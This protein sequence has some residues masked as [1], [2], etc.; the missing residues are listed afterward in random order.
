MI[1][2]LDWINEGSG[3]INESIEAQYVNISI[4]IYQFPLIGSTCIELPDELKNT[5]KGL[6]N[7]KK[8]TINVFFGVISDV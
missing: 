8:I 7:I 4:S 6:I 1:L 5:V 3:W 2:I